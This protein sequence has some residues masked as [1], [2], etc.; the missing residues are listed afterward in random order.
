V[1]SIAGQRQTGAGSRT[2]RLGSAGTACLPSSPAVTCA[3]AAHRP[4][5]E[6]DDRLPGRAGSHFPCDRP[7]SAGAHVRDVDLVRYGQ[8]YRPTPG[9]K[10]EL[11]E[12]YRDLFPKL[13][14]FFTRRE[15][16][17]VIDRL[18]RGK[19]G[20]SA[21]VRADR[22]P[23]GRPLHVLADLL[24]SAQRRGTGTGDH[25]RSLRDRSD[26]LQCDR[27]P[28]LLRHGLPDGVGPARGRRGVARP[29]ARDATGVEDRRPPQARG[30]R[31][32]TGGGRGFE[33]ERSGPWFG[34][35]TYPRAATSVP[36][37]FESATKQKMSGGGDV[38]ESSS[39]QH[40][41]DRHEALSRWRGCHRQHPWPWAQPGAVPPGDRRLGDE[42]PVGS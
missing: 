37:H 32:A 14:P 28:L 4:G 33:G 19:P 39:R 25:V 12:S 24:R 35:S 13:M 23:L 29:A 8:G 7:R 9:Q 30:E 22:L 11:E 5:E 42:R 1:V 2:G 31:S 17:Q 21:A 15:L 6:L 20:Q 18:L 34:A 27:G 36:I 40:V 26:R 41:G 3:G 16:V 38:S 10:R